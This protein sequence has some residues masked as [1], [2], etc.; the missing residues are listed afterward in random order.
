MQQLTRPSGILS[1]LQEILA[2]HIAG[3]PSRPPKHAGPAAHALAAAKVDARALK[4]ALYGFCVSAPLGHVLVGRLQRV[5]AGRT[6]T[7]AKV[8]QI[9]ASNLL[10]APVQTVGAWNGRACGCK[11]K[12]MLYASVSC[13]HGCDWGREISW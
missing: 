10:I 6:S 2:S 4:M 9:V 3:V 1:F 7:G 13:V 5:F 11:G 8:A 12:L